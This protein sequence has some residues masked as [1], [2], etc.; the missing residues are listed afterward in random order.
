ML[1]LDR[2]NSDCV[3]PVYTEECAELARWLKSEPSQDT[4]MR[5]WFS[6]GAAARVKT[7]QTPLER[8]GPQTGIVRRF[9]N[10][11]LESSPHRP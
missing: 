6:S 4:R 2:A 7:N 5:K 8:Q 9:P 3:F 1:R 11:F 10:N